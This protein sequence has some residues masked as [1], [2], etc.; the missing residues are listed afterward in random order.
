MTQSSL[1]WDASSSHKSPTCG[2]QWRLCFSYWLIEDAFSCFQSTGVAKF[3]VLILCKMHF[4]MYLKLTWSIVNRKVTNN[5]V[6]KTWARHVYAGSVTSQPLF[7]DVQKRNHLPCCSCL[8]RPNVMTARRRGETS[9]ILPLCGT[10]SGG[11]ST[12]FGYKNVGQSY[13][14][15]SW[16]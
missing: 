8:Q 9:F 3:I 4:K 14:N 15:I 7:S 11:K 6:A 2:T 10:L 1:W 5:C 13:A 12:T 16:S